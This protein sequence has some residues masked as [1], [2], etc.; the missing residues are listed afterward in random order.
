MSFNFTK[1]DDR[2]REIQ[3]R[4]RKLKGAKA[5][6]KA[7]VIGAKA[8]SSHVDGQALTNVQLAAVHEYGMPERG[9]P[10]RSF[11]RA[12]FREHREEYRALLIKLV[13]DGV[14]EGKT[15][16]RQAL[17]LLGQKMAADMKD[18][19]TKNDWEPNSP[20]TIA[21]KGSSR[22]LIDTGALRASITYEVVDPEGEAHG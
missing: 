5:Y 6:A 21:R 13:Q 18:K 10:E 19:F 17:G 7:G 4:V 14:L 20:T 2:W 9:I 16:M 1:K 15:S 12:T 22:P 3:E 8:T 11:I